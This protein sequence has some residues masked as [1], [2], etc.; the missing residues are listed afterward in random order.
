MSNNAARE[1]RVRRALRKKGFT[2]RKSRCRTF[3]FGINDQGG[4][5]VLDAY[6]NTIEAGEKLDLSLEDVEHGACFLVL[7]PV[8]G[9]GEGAA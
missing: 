5:C 8:E 9:Q 7:L 2:L 3:P 6:R 4:Y 1:A